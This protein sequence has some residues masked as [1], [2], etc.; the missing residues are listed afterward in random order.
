MS[1]VA[2]GGAGRQPVAARGH[3]GRSDLNRP[4]ALAGA[5]PDVRAIMDRVGGENFPVASRLLPRAQREHLLA[6][7][8]YARL[9]DEIGDAR[10]PEADAE[11]LLD[12]VEDELDRVYGG[13]AEPQHPLMRSL[14]ATVRACGIPRYPLEALI[15]A[16]RQDQR[17]HA[18]RT[19][20]QLVGYCEQSA[21][22]VGHLVLYVL[23]A[24]TPERMALSD[25]ICTALQLTEH[26][27]DVVE[28][29]SRGRVYLPAEDLDRFGCSTED[30]AV[31]PALERVRRLMRFEVERAR[32]LLEAGTPLIGTLRGR[33]R[34]AVAAYVAGGRA[35]LS[36]IQRRGYDV[37][38]GAPRASRPARV[39]RTLIVG[40]TRR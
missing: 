29:L 2:H 5:F 35:A 9:V 15:A 32:D 14:R 13:E 7:Y 39:A 4:R 25:R 27:Q 28:D 38:A 26:W 8:G 3:A 22:P 31:S 12:R 19:F 33:A 10:A 36:A 17:V 16:N 20:S 34:W 37:S 11:A 21:N 1:A 40:W 18:Y 30:L 24:A 6:L 23:G